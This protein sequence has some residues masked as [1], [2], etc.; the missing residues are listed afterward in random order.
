MSLNQQTSHYQE[1]KSN[2]RNERRNHYENVGEVNLGALELN[3]YDSLERKPPV[4]K[5]YNW[6][7]GFMSPYTKS[8]PKDAFPPQS[9]ES[10][11][12]KKS[13]INTGCWLSVVLV[14]MM[15]I[16]STSL[17][18]SVLIIKGIIV[19]PH[20]SKTGQYTE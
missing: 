16:S 6:H 2:T 12:P 10:V 20:C 3:P 7:N 19:T 5:P 9:L 17:A 14:I 11:D 18:I 15:I 4:L 1:P 13:C 8:I